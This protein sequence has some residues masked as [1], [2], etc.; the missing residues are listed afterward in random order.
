MNKF[1]LYLCS[2]SKSINTQKSY[3]KAVEEY[4]NWFSYSYGSEVN[5]LY[6]ENI[7]EYK[8]Y[9]RNIKKYKGKALNANTIN[10]KIS[11]LLAYNKFLIEAGIQKD[12]VIFKEDMIKVQ[13]NV[14]NP[15][16]VN[17]NEVEVFRQKVL[18]SG[19]ARLYA[20]ITILAYGGLRI[21]E[22]LDLKLTNINFL[23][24]DII[25]GNGK[26]NKQ[27]AIYMNSKIENAI[28]KYLKVRQDKGE[29]LCVSRERDKLDRTVV[30]KEFKK[31]SN[32]ITP[33]MLRHFFCSNALENG[34]TIAEVANLAGHKS[35]QT[36]L[37]YTN[38]SVEKMKMKMELL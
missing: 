21:S 17:K 27:R 5:R 16:T 25:I 12:I 1:R 38:P 30:N 37:I 6:R 28:K 26:G 22:A 19:N 29:Y 11:A 32:F 34:F 31:Y 20:I 2:K 10:V 13:M 4:E 8:S 23:S 24:K 15:C 35:V 36:T 9:L 33:H 7:L 3:I 18:E 14:A